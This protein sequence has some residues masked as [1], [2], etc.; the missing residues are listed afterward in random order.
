VA[1]VKSLWGLIAVK[2]GGWKAYETIKASD[3]ARTNPGSEAMI[4]ILKQ[5][6][7]CL[8]LLDEVVAYARNLE[9]IPYDGFVSFLRSLT[10]AA[11]AVPGVLVVGTLP[12][13]RSEVGDDR[14]WAALLQLQ[15]VFGRVQSAWT[16]AQGTETFEIIRRRLF[17]ELDPEG[18]KAR[19]QAVKAFTS[20][21]RNNAG[22]FPSGVR[23]RAYEAQLIAAYPVHPELF[24][25]LQGDW[26]GLQ[27]FQKTRGVLK[28]MAQI[29]YRHWRDGHGAP[30]IMPGDVPLTDDKVRTNALVPLPTGYDAVLSK[31][32]AGDLSK[33]AQIE[34]RSPSIGKNK[35]VTRAATALFMATAPH[36]STNNCRDAGR[37]PARLLTGG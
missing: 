33:P 28:M 29:V 20:Y 34:A 18:E 13:S 1:G 25:M 37:P 12:V 3:E 30:M 21:Y 8:V 9:G 10:E 4:A 5:A 23:E 17:Q 24:P 31:E 15:Q 14:G 35:A 7:P 16:A 22:E 6:A 19:E 2:L 36:G 26:G 11:N 27:N 32:V